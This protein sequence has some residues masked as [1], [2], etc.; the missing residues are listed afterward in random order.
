VNTLR[1]LHRAVVSERGGAVVKYLLVVSLC[2][3]MAVAVVDA[4]AGRF[5][6]GPAAF[7]A[8]AR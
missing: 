6:P 5:S 3:L 7:T 8:A 2:A 4:R 1:R